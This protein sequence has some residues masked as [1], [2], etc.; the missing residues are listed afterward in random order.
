MVCPNCNID[1]IPAGQWE[2]CT[3]CGKTTYVIQI[4]P[5]QKEIRDAEE[6]S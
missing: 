1:M 5:Y 4:P 3:K 2:R 6:I